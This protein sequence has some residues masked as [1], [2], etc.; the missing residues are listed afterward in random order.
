MTVL[1]IIAILIA[2]GAGFYFHERYWPK[3]QQVLREIW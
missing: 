1:I 3:V 2:F